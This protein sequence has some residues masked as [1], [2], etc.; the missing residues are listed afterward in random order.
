MESG[1]CPTCGDKREPLQFFGDVESIRFCK[2]CEVSID[3]DGTETI[4][5]PEMKRLCRELGLEEG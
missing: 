1:N 4:Q 3:A 5:T 2:K